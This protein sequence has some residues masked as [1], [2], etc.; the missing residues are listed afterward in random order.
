MWAQSRLLSLHVVRTFQLTL[1]FS[2]YDKHTVCSI[3]CW[4]ISKTCIRFLRI[5]FLFTIP[6][7]P[8]HAYHLHNLRPMF[9]C[10]RVS[11]LPDMQTVISTAESQTSFPLQPHWPPSQMPLRSR[12]VPVW[13]KETSR[14]QPFATK[15]AVCSWRQLFICLFLELALMS[16]ISQ[17]RSL[18]NFHL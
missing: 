4:H 10:W 1:Y 14:L 9:H 13:E 15:L 6:S 5:R 12:C 3:T 16:K 2:W 8:G 17:W 18:K 7:Y 11:T